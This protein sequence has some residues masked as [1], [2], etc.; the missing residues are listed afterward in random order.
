MRVVREIM[1][2]LTGGRSKASVFATGDL[3]PSYPY[4]LIEQKEGPDHHLSVWGQQEAMW[5]RSLRTGSAETPRKNKIT[6]IHL[7]H[8][9]HGPC[10]CFLLH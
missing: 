3:P 2:R 10:I 4:R 8:K 6:Y 5:A 1:L 7:L 9:G